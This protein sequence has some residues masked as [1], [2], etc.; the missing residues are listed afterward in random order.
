MT[1]E[2]VLILRVRFFLINGDS[3][4]IVFLQ[5]DNYKES[6]ARG[7]PIIVD[8]YATL[9]TQNL[10]INQRIKLFLT[11]IIILESFLMSH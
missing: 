6:S 2:K 7:V 11:K 5:E 3:F 1:I 10:T 9:N 4:F 8:S